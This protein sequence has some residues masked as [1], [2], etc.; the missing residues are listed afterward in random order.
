MEDST[1]DPSAA[2]GGLCMGSESED[3]E[4]PEDDAEDLGDNAHLEEEHDE[5]GDEAPQNAESQSTLNPESESH[6]TSSE[7]SEAQKEANDA[8]HQISNVEELLRTAQSKFAIDI[9][10][11]KKVCLDAMFL[12]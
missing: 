9:E 4:L 7:D 12:R 6:N 10:N 5:T 8:I 2:I 1:A 11:A 3:E